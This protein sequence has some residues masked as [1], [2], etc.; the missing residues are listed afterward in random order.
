MS[1]REVAF[2]DLGLRGKRLRRAYAAIGCLDSRYRQSKLNLEED[3][4][5]T[6][7]PHRTTFVEYITVRWQDNVSGDEADRLFVEA[8]EEASTHLNYDELRCGE[9]QDCW[10]GHVTSARNLYRAVSAD[11]K[12]LFLEISEDDFMRDILD[13]ELDYQAKKLANCRL[14]DRLMW[15]W[16]NIDFPRDPFHNIA[17]NR[18]ELVSRL[19]LV[20]YTTPE[21]RDE[22]LV[23]WIHEVPPSIIVRIPT[24]LDARLNEQW[25]HGGRTLPINARTTTEGLPEAVHDPITGGCLRRKINR[26]E[27]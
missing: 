14:R 9:A 10:F 13:A 18:A 17:E 4:N 19:G 24:A 11:C 21:R 22:L 27:R 25:Y 3:P 23:A 6:N 15:V 8:M 20:H 1:L 2:N 5:L 12:V 7:R 26:L 16:Y